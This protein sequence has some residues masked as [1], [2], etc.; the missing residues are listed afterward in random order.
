[1]AE[2]VPIQPRLV[3]RAQRLVTISVIAPVAVYL[4][5]IAALTFSGRPT[6]VYLMGVVVLTIG[7]GIVGKWTYQGIRNIPTGWAS[8][9]FFIGF[10]TDYFFLMLTFGSERDQRFGLEDAPFSVAILL[11]ALGIVLLGW[12]P[13]R[14][15]AHLILDNLPTEVVDSSLVI[16]FTARGKRLVKLSVTPDS[17]D[18][19]VKPNSGSLTSE[20]SYRLTDVKAVSV[21][22][23]TDDGECPVPGAT[24]RP[25]LVSRG[26]VI[27]V[28]LPEGQLVFPGK[29]DAHQIKRFIEERMHRATVEKDGRWL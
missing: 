11:L 14:R 10:V 26:E 21:R 7:L 13:G 1:M 28:D 29:R 3:A 9:G 23:E 15:A 22:T 5:V 19:V 20:G 18:I 25:I 6:S 24:G 16:K 4:A 8:G 27:V 2:P 17:L 12:L